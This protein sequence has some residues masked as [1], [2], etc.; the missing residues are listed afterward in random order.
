MA[1]SGGGFVGGGPNGL[2]YLEGGWPPPVV[3]IVNRLS[4]PLFQARVGTWVLKHVSLTFLF[5][6]HG[7]KGINILLQASIIC[8]DPRQ[9]LW[10]GKTRF[11][12]RFLELWSSTGEVRLKNLPIF[13]PEAKTSA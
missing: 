11:V 3:F 9:L 7:E 2:L 4:A 1:G 6:S 10:A 5:I 8:S 12:V 13:A